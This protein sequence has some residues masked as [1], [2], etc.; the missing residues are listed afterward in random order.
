MTAAVGKDTSGWY[1][2]VTSSTQHGMISGLHV[3]YHVS[4]HGYYPILVSDKRFVDEFRVTLEGLNK[5][6]S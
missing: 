6:R 5:C 3:G 1:A 2:I 4:K